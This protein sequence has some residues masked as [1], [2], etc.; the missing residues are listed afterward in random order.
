VPQL[1]VEGEVEF[2]A[3]P[4]VLDEVDDERL[5]SAHDEGQPVVIR[6]DSA[7]KVIAALTRPEVA[8]VIVPPEQ[9][10]LLEIDLVELTY[11]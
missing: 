4:L 3:D 7:E 8:C 1:A 6:A 2:P 5:R 10:D 11:G 9:R